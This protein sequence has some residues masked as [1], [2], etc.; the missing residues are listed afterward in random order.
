MQDKVA[1]MHN[2]ISEE[3][4]YISNNNNFHTRWWNE[5]LCIWR[6]RNASLATA[7]PVRHLI[8]VI[9]AVGRKPAGGYSPRPL[10]HFRSGGPVEVTA[11]KTSEW[12]RAARDSQY[13]RGPR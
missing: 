10:L 3:Y 1:P 7:S 12:A 13:R 4:K 8:V 6:R 9:T 2:S 5:E 11:A